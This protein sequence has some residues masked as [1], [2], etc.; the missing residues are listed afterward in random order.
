MTSLRWPRRCPSAPAPR[1]VRRRQ[2][3]RRQA[4]PDPSRAHAGAGRPC[5]S[6]SNRCAGRTRRCE[7]ASSCQRHRAVARGRV[8]GG[9]TARSTSAGGERG[10][11]RRQR[12]DRRVAGDHRRPR[13]PCPRATARRTGSES[14]LH[15]APEAV[16]DAFATWA[17]RRVM[18]DTGSPP[19]DGTGASSSE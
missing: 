5:A 3:A 18:R 17:L 13:R 8:A 6:S 12:L 16:G 15:A 11:R 9:P 2:G 7:H 10:D 19:S 1:A 4:S 14:G